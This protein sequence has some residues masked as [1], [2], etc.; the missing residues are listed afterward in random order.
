LA[1]PAPLPFEAAVTSATLSSKTPARF[2][3]IV[4]KTVRAAPALLAPAALPGAD[5][6]AASRIAA[7]LR[8]AIPGPY[9]H[10]R[11]RSAQ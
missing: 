4:V 7:Y 8:G 6:F 11:Q 1:L 3:S 9:R 10:Q 2:C 5:P